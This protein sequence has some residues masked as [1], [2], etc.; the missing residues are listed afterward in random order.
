MVVGLKVYIDVDNPQ[1]FNDTPKEQSIQQSPGEQE[2]FPLGKQAQSKNESNCKQLDD[3]TTTQSMQQSP[4][5][6]EQ[7]HLTNQRQNKDET[8]GELGTLF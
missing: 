3:T 1:Q 8:N 5:E 2:Q 4:G 7:R 6:Q